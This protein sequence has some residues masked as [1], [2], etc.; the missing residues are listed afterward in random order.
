MRG[1]VVGTAHR[2]PRANQPAGFVHSHGAGARAAVT[3]AIAPYATTDGGYLME[4]RFRFLVAR[5]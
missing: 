3:E 4:N 2:A 1:G 5:A